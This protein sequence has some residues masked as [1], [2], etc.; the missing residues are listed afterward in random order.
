MTWYDADKGFGFVTPDSGGEDVFVHV[1]ALAGGLSELAD[2][3]R[4]TYEVTEGERG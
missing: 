4:V 2:G 1:R 3:D